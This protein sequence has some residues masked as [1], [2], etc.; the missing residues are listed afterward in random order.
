MNKAW[1]V[2]CNPNAVAFVPLLFGTDSFGFLPLLSIEENEG[3]L[4]HFL[5][6]S[7]YRMSSNQLICLVQD[8]INTLHMIH[9]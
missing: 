8:V 9:G 4:I 1:L 2:G 7:F 5:P 3:C 6:F